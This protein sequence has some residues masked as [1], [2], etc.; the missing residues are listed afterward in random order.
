MKPRTRSLSNLYH[1]YGRERGL[2]AE[3]VSDALEAEGLIERISAD[4]YRERERKPRLEKEAFEALVHEV[5]ERA[6]QRER[7]SHESE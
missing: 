4:S 7:R 6:V 1:R 2:E 5:L 3:E